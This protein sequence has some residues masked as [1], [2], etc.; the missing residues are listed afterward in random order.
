MAGRQ[1]RSV[2]LERGAWQLGPKTTIRILLF[3]AVFALLSGLCLTQT[4]KVSTT[5]HRISEKEAQRKRLQQQ[6]DMLLV[7]IMEIASLPRLE[8]R[9]LELGYGHAERVRYLPIPGYLTSDTSEGRSAPGQRLDEKTVPATR[10]GASVASKEHSNK[11]LDVGR[12]WGKVLSQLIAWARR[13]P[14]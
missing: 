12:W 14:Q 11:P 9:A 4:I 10:L 13:P 7:E 8:H 3:L 6:N 5:R 1:N 2:R